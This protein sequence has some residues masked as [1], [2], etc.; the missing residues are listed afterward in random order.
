LL[1]SGFKAISLAGASITERVLTT[2]QF[3][4][5]DLQQ[6][7]SRRPMVKQT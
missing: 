6:S 1:P 2:S 3:D 5:S 4:F 7:A